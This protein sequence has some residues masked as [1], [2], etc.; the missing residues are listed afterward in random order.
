MNF[1]TIPISTSRRGFTLIE[2][3]VVIA[4]IAIL[5][6]LLLPALAKAKAKALSIKC[7]SNVKQMTLGVHLFAGDNQDLLPYGL[8]VAG[9]PTDID[10]NVNTSYV[11]PGVASSH[12]QLVYQL[13]PYIPGAKVMPAYPNWAV[14]LVAV[15]PSY[16]ANPQYNARASNPAEPNY[17][18]ACYRL[19]KNVEGNRLFTANNF[20]L[21]NVKQP[22]GNG[23]LA[24]LDRKTPGC[25][26]GP[27][28]VGLADWNQL[29]DNPVHGNSRNYGW[30]DGHVSSLTLLKHTNSMTTGQSPY[31]WI[32]PLQ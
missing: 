24:D 17:S 21:A 11:V 13:A 20:K 4:I 18:R 1:F 29:P 30:F 10:W 25:D 26:S 7:V 8:D 14:N 2:L 6:G 15:C 28:S 23:M 3:L 16:N 5:A 12:P 22:S 32:Y 31:G 9:N 27:N 19:R